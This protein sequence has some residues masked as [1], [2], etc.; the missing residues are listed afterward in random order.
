M[1]TRRRLEILASIAAIVAAAPGPLQATGCN[2]SNDNAVPAEEAG[3]DASEPGDASGVDAGQGEASVEAGHTITLTWQVAVAPPFA[4]EGLDGGGA[5]AGG[6]LDAGSDAPSDTGTGA[7]SEAGSDAAGPEASTG[8]DAGPEAAASGGPPD[9]AGDGGVSPLDGV[10]VCVYQSSA[11]PCVTTDADGTFALP[12]LP[13]MSNLAVTFTKDGYVPVVA[14]LATPNTDLNVISFGAPPVLMPS[15]TVA[16]VTP[17]PSDM[18][19]KG[20]VD[21]VAV[22][23]GSSGKP[24]DSTGD[25]GARFTLSPMTG[26]GPYFLDRDNM[27]IVPSAT[28]VVYEVGVYLNL[29]P[30]NYEVTIDD[31][32]HTCSPLSPVI[33]VYGYPAPPASVK[34]PI[35]KGYNTNAV[36]FYCTAKSTVVNTADA[37]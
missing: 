6:G 1:M 35:L 11:I 21:V 37:N 31:P 7:T 13:A 9:A 28:S 19:N 3:A 25:V 16:S 17:V 23:P 30:G 4:T 15:S 2:S 32:D 8:S 14:A 24:S 10:S 5:G 29:D 18:S 33:G 36:A 22:V 20:S 27:S 26:N 12:G 34:F